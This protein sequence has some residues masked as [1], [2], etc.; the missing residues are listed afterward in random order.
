MKTD[1]I[2]YA[3]ARIED[4]SIAQ[5]G[6]ADWARLVRL[7]GRLTELREVPA[8]INSPT[9]QA[10]TIVAVASGIVVA[11]PGMDVLRYH[12]DDAPYVINIDHYTIIEN[13]HLNERYSEVLKV[14]GLSDSDELRWQ[15]QNNIF[16]IKEPPNDFHWMTEFPDHVLNAERR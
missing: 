12:E 7:D 16:I 2:Y 11:A 13:L 5:M 3:I 10:S 8:P 15:L 4:K 14:A 9:L 6:Y 1:R